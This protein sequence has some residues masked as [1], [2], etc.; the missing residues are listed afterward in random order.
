MSQKYFHPVSNGMMAD[1]DRKLAGM[2][3]KDR[4]FVKE[5]MAEQY[6]EKTAN[7][8][9]LRM[10]VTPAD[11]GHRGGP[12]GSMIDRNGRTIRGEAK[13]EKSPLS[14]GQRNPVKTLQTDVEKSANSKGQFG[15]ASNM[16]K[17]V[18]KQTSA[19]LDR[20]QGVPYDVSRSRRV[21]GGFETKVDSR[22][23]MSR[24]T[25]TKGGP[26]TTTQDAS[27]ISGGFKP[28]VQTSFGL[29]DK[30]GFGGPGGGM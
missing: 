27:N 23:Y 4:N 14:N 2:S 17:Q 18:A 29:G 26:V 16:D 9:G 6:M 19:T 22:N 15:K 20:G 28:A 24:Q 10:T 21:S 1:Y 25:G 5:V 12:D 13:A 8:R 7:Q 30:K 3:E 11:K